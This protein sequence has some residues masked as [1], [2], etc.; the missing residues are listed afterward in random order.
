VVA[1][2]SEMTCYDYAV[3]FPDSGPWTEVF[4]SDASDSELKLGSLFP[5]SLELQ[6]RSGRYHD[7]SWLHGLS[8]KEA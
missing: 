3:G 8:L 1:T 2:L 7:M 4:N 6:L 5:F